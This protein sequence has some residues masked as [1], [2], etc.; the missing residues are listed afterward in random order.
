MEILGRHDAGVVDDDVKAGVLGL[1][2]G[3]EALEV[4]RV[5]DIQGEGVHAGVRTYGVVQRGL[6]APRDQYLVA[7]L[8]EDFGERAA[9]PAAA[10]GDKDRVAAGCHGV[11]LRGEDGRTWFRRTQDSWPVPPL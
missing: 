10:A 9:N 8:V 4:V 5:F 6:A 11:C 3:D 1:H 2:L 7:L